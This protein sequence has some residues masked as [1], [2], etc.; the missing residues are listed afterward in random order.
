[1]ALKPKIDRGTWLALAAAGL[2]GSVLILGCAAHLVRYRGDELNGIFAAI[3]ALWLSGVLCQ[4]SRFRP[5]GEGLRATAIFFLMSVTAALST[6]VLARTNA[7]YA[8][9]LFVAADRLVFPGF[10][11]PSA[12]IALDQHRWITRALD[13]SYPTLFWQPELL[14]IFFC[15]TGRSEQAWRALSALTIALILCI[16]V[17]PFCPAIGGYAY[18][19]IGWD[20]V[21]NVHEVAAWRYPEILEGVRQGRIDELGL[22]TLEGVVAMPSYHASAAVILAWGFW[23]A[24]YLRWPLLLLNI[25]MLI[26][27]VPIGG[28]YIVD[29]LAGCATACFSIWLVRIFPT[30]SRRG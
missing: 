21:P 10:D 8:D 7:P 24:R 11:W 16:A 4:G 27:S 15:A 25:M 29:V 30:S 19:G 28:H 18:F 2:F 20:S 22:K 13:Y 26:S 17:F 5:L 6:T 23:P 12:M 3:V 1:M 14:L 9:A